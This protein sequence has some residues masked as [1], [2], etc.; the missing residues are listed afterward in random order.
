MVRLLLKKWSDQGLPCLLFRQ[1]FCEFQTNI[2]FENRKRKALGNFRTFTYINYGSLRTEQ[3]S[4]VKIIF[5]LILIPS[6]SQHAKSTEPL[7]KLS[8]AHWKPNSC[9]SPLQLCTLAVFK[10]FLISVEENC[11]FQGLQWVMAEYHVFVSSLS[12]AIFSSHHQRKLL[13]QWQVTP[14]LH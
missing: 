13:L 12:H 2:L 7:M 14:F 4:I 5:L 6:Q 9:C 1:A 3:I 11:F 8:V 10:L